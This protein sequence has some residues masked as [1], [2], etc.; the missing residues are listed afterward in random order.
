MIETGLDRAE[1]FD[2]SEE[3]WTILC[4][5]GT[6]ELRRKKTGLRVFRP[7]RTQTGLYSYRRC[8]VAGNFEFS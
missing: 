6:Y 5:S 2:V 7:G 4:D 8:L 3:V 1:E